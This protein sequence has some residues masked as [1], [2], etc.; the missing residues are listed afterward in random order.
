MLVC[1]GIALDS[2]FP[3]RMHQMRAH[4]I[5]VVA[6]LIQAHD[7]R[8]HGHQQREQQQRHAERQCHLVD[9]VAL[10]CIRSQHQRWRLITTIGVVTIAAVDA[11]VSVHD[12]VTSMEYRTASGLLCELSVSI[13]D[14]GRVR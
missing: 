9:V 8:Q 11:I 13:R 7:N 14:C 10:R 6:V 2:H 4:H 5:A 3:I 1:F 12:F